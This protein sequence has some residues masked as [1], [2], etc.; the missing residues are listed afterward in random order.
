MFPFCRTLPFSICQSWLI[1]SITLAYL[2]SSKSTFLFVSPFFNQRPIFPCLLILSFEHVYSPSC[3]LPSCSI[4]FPTLIDRSLFSSFHIF[5]CISFMA[6]SA[7]HSFEISSF[8]FIF[9]SLSNP[10]SHSIYT[11]SSLNFPSHFLPLFFFTRSINSYA[12]L[13]CSLL[14]SISLYVYPL[15]SI[16]LIMHCHHG[17]SITLLFSLSIIIK[18][19]K[20]WHIYHLALPKTAYLSLRTAKN[21][22]SITLHCPSWHIYHLLCFSIIFLASYPI[23]KLLFSALIFPMAFTSLFLSYFILLS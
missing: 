4:Y 6:F 18:H 20:K 11:P 19:C 23:Y 9:P 7:F 22:I 21:G 15:R 14:Y 10:I 3:F 5:I 8:H 12:Q 1:F 13:I 17:I 2:C 16:H